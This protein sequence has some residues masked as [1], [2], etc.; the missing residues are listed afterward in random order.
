MACWQPCFPLPWQALEAI[1]T[2]LLHGCSAPQRAPLGG[3]PPGSA[4]SFKLGAGATA[5]AGGEVSLLV[6]A[7]RGS[8][9]GPLVVV[10]AS[11]PA[12][13]PPEAP[14][15]PAAGQAAAAEEECEAAAVGEVWPFGTG[16]DDGGGSQE[17]AR[18]RRGR[19][20]L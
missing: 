2:V 15:R 7:R 20:S 19:I 1:R 10:D 11:A 17:R 4:V 13:D 16:D 3:A 6:D 12:L 18:C 5:T 14:A 9:S 8:V